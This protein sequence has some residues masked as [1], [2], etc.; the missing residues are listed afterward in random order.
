MFNLKAR[1]GLFILTSQ[2]YRT[3]AGCLNGIDSVK[4]NAPADINYDRF[5]SG[6]EKYYF[7]L[8]AANEEIIGTSEM[9]ESSSAREIGVDSVKINAPEATI[10][11][12]A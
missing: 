10:E 7:N 4:R 8:K 11:D 3:K 6:N 2:A 9:Y 5:R 1:N 12:L